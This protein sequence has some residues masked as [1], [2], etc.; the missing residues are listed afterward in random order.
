MGGDGDFISLLP[1]QLTG[2]PGG[3]PGKKGFVQP[4]A[5]R[6]PGEGGGEIGIFLPEQRQ[7][8]VAEIVPGVGGVR[9]ALVLPVR[10][11]ICV[12]VIRNLSPGQLQQ[13][14]DNMSPPGRNTPQ[15]LETAPP[16]QV[17]QQGFRVVVGVV[18]G[19]DI[20]RLHRS[21]AVLQ[22]AVAQGAPRLLQGHALLLSKACH[23]SGAGMTGN[24]MLPAPLEDKIHIPGGLR[25]EPVVKGGGGEPDAALSAPAPEK[26]EQHHGVHSAGDGAEDAA[27]PLQG[28][29]LPPAEGQHPRLP[30]YSSCFH[31]K[32]EKAVN[33]GSH[34]TITLPVS[35]CRFLA[36]MISA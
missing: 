27:A 10:E 9:I 12:A 33:S 16:K 30:V 14:T 20:V 6:R 28:K 4:E 31:S 23:I 21:A 32:L 5:L 15:P 1:Q 8:L 34:C 19:G 18:G 35:P 17:E 3:L 22:K 24:L 26:V 7:H 2:E 11:I 13:G 29:A 36:T 25:P